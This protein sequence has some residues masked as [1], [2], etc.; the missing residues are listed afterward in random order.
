ML[1]EILADVEYIASTPPEVG[2]VELWRVVGII[3][4]H[5]SWVQQAMSQLTSL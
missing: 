3:V 4:L 1:R 2:R 5:R